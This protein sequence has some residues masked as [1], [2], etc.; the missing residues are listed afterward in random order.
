MTFCFGSEHD[1]PEREP[2]RLLVTDLVPEA[3][4][5]V[6][7]RGAGRAVPGLLGVTRD[8]VPRIEV[9]KDRRPQQQ[10]LSRERQGHALLAVHRG[11]HR[12]T[13]ETRVDER[14][15]GVSEAV[16]ERTQNVRKE[17][18]QEHG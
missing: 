10:P 8:R 13:R 4:P 16:I 12:H 6:V 14:T 11:P 5:G 7:E 1:G 15:F 2:V 17:R 9:V 18:C 3:R